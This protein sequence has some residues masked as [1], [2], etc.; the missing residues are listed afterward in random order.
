MTKTEYYQHDERIKK[1]VLGTLGSYPQ[2]ATHDVYDAY[3][4]QRYD[5]VMEYL[6]SELTDEEY[7]AFLKHDE[8]EAIEMV[9]REANRVNNPYDMAPIDNM[10]AS[11]F[12]GI[13]RKEAGK[14]INKSFYH[15]K[16]PKNGDELVVPPP[17]RPKKLSR[18]ERKKKNANK[19][20]KNSELQF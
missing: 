14:M 8:E 20:R 11:I 1:I 16:P 9:K 4:R 10:M 13:L 2:N 6:S 18:A 12:G 19:N 7:R 15:Q 17:P 3:E 5:L